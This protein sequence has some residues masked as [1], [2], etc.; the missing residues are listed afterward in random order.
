M[1]AYQVSESYQ[2]NYYRINIKPFFVKD[3]NKYLF[4]G[5]KATRDSTNEYKFILDTLRCHLGDDLELK[6]GFHIG[7]F[8]IGFL[9]N[10]QMNLLRYIVEDTG[11]YPIKYGRS[12]LKFEIGTYLYDKPPCGSG[13]CHCFECIQSC[14][15]YEKN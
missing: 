1:S 3:Y 4:G 12:Q 9:S 13:E 11:A 2:T 8:E 5:L 14:G 15:V 7:S 10:E 6:E